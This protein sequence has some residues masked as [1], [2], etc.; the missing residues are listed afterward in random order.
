MNYETFMSLTENEQKSVPEEELPMIPKEQLRNFL[1]SSRMVKRDGILGWEIVQEFQGNKKQEWF[2]M[3]KE[4][5]GT[6]PTIIFQYQFNPYNGTYTMRPDPNLEKSM[7]EEPIGMY[8]REWMDFMEKN[9][10][11]ETEYLR[12]K[13]KFLTL[14]RQVQKSAE[15]YRDLLE[16]QYDRENPRPHPNTAQGFNETLKWGE[17]KQFY[18]NGEV[19]REKVLICLTET[20]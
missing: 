11:M 12:M 7:T 16:E 1:T 19:M 20:D 18:V 6:V 4:K 14:A 13:H 2:P 5:Q 15:D 3:Y 9:Y 8:G 17:M 10:P